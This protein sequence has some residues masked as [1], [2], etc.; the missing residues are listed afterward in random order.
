[1]GDNRAESTYEERQTE[2]LRRMR[3]EIVDL[4]RHPEAWEKWARFRT[5][6]H[7]YSFRNQMRILSQRPDAKRVMG[8]RKWQESG[9]QVQ[10]GEEGI[11]IRAPDEKTASTAVEAMSHDVN[12]GEPYLDGF[13]DVVVFGW[14]QT[15]PIVDRSPSDID[16]LVPFED[17]APKDIPE[18]RM[19]EAAPLSNVLNERAQTAQEAGME[20]LPEPIPLLEEEGHD[21]I[22]E[23]AKRFVSK[24]GYN[25]EVMDKNHRAKGGFWYRARTIKYRQNIPVAQMAKTIVHELCHAITIEHLGETET[26]ALG[27]IGRELIAEGAAYLACYSLGLDAAAY[28]FPYMRAT[29]IGNVKEGVANSP[30]E[31]KRGR[32]SKE[33]ERYLKPMNRVA[34]AAREGIVDGVHD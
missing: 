32:V 3:E 22:L 30:S 15:I 12:V 6:F 7:D 17:R 5:R 2:G 19:A 33:L 28:S 8:Y 29:A 26:R 31:E 20:S 27:H 1:M 14:E 16:G 34:R 23:G 24:Q 25:L 9:R 4:G 13:K 18:G 11:W 10:H 21:Q